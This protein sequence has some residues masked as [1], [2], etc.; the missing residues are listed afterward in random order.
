MKN[1]KLFTF[2]VLA[3]E[4]GLDIP[5]AKF[6]DTMMK[7][8]LAEGVP[9]QA[10][11][12]PTFMQPIFQTREGYGQGCPWTCPYHEGEPVEYSV[13]MC[14]K[15]LEYLSRVIHL[16]IPPPMTVEDCDMVARGINKVAAALA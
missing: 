9:A 10:F 1:I 8:L 7:A 14:P 11:Q 12:V 2:K 16:D 4:L 3:R 5:Q 6:R 13:D 15:T